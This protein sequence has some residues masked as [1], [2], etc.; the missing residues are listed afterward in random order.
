MNDY[1][2]TLYVKICAKKIWSLKMFMHEGGSLQEHVNIHY[3]FLYSSTSSL[4]QSS[5]KMICTWKTLIRAFKAA[6]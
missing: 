5:N 1:T 6:V 2:Y 3:H 4:G